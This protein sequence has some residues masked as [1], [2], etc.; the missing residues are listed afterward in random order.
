ML[1]HLKSYLFGGTNELVQ[2]ELEEGAANVN[3]CTPDDDWVLVDT[4]GKQHLCLF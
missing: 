2:D 1:S 3:N 4:Q